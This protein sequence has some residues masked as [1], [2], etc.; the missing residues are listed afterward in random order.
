MREKG[1]ERGGERVRGRGVF[2]SPGRLKR[3]F[4]VRD[5]EI[6][7]EASNRF[8]SEDF[9]LVVAQGDLS[10][11]IFVD[12]E[13]LVWLKSTLEVSAAN[14]WAVLNGC[15]YSGGRRTLR[16]ASFLKRGV[17]FLNVSEWCRN[18][19][20]FFVNIPGE[21]NSDGWPVLLKA[22]T[23]ITVERVPPPPAK[24]CPTKSFAEIVLGPEMNLEG[25]CVLSAEATVEVGDLGV[26]NRVCYLERCLCFRFIN[27]IPEKVN[28]KV[29]RAWMT[30]N[31]GISSVSKIMC[32]G[33]D[34]W[35]VECP[36]KQAVDMIVSLNRCLYGSTRIFLDRWTEK[37]GRTT[38][39]PKQRMVWVLI[40]GIPLHL[41]SLEL[42]KAIGE[43]CGGFVD[44][45][46]SLC[47]LNSVRIKVVDTNTIP[48]K[49]SL[50]FR[51]NLFMVKVVK[52]LV[53][54]DRSG[55]EASSLKVISSTREGVRQTFVAEWRRKHLRGKAKV[56]EEGESSAMA[57][58]KTLEKGP[59]L[60]SES[61]KGEKGVSLPASV[62]GVRDLDISGITQMTSFDGS[63]TDVMCQSMMGLELTRG[64]GEGG[65]K[66]VQL[67]RGY[68]GVYVGLMMAGDFGVCVQSRGGTLPYEGLLKWRVAS[69]LDPSSGPRC[70]VDK[71]VIGPKCG[72]S[73]VY[74]LY[75]KN[76]TEATCCSILGN[77]GAELIMR[78]DES[79]VDALVTELEE[80][81]SSRKK[82]LESVDRVVQVLDLQVSNSA[83]KA[84]VS[85]R[86]SAIA[87]LDRRKA[88]GRKSKT[89][90]ELAKLGITLESAI[91]NH[92]RERRNGMN[93]SGPFLYES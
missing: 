34:L 1:G 36:S 27:K 25:R 51:N 77:I 53:E 70:W 10:H 4:Q 89:E 61:E 69:F 24:G 38:L 71:H 92:P 62:T 55:V 29:F 2:S 84:L 76:L 14:S 31:W 60:S 87:V 13:E 86:Q 5:V 3:N 41:R 6:T 19:R 39:L 56:L 30:K 26:E 72:G 23:E 59:V 64:V 73:L 32:L 20:R 52:E 11:F 48:E 57:Q 88:S 44:Y 17:R 40:Q 50:R 81:K 54:A 68:F 47:P 42:F 21:V 37:A 12:V 83:E 80:E 63:P 43:R 66:V 18:G 58:G 45:D 85:V 49:V 28:W 16:L 9:R 35:M 79:S 67:K 22:L 75:E 33:D 7:L 46:D 65:S 78:E 8:A 82:I 90:R 74:G 15:Q 91:V 93:S